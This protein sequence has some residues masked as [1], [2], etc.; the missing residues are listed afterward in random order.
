MSNKNVLPLPGYH[1]HAFGLE[2]CDLCRQSPNPASHPPSARSLKGPTPTGF[3]AIAAGFKKKDLKKMIKEQ[4]GMGQDV[5]HLDDNNDLDENHSDQD[6]SQNAAEVKPVFSG[7]TA[8][9]TLAAAEMENCNQH[10]EERAKSNFSK[11]RV[12]VKAKVSAVGHM[13]TMLDTSKEL[14]LSNEILELAIQQIGSED[15]RS[16]KVAAYDFMDEII[17]R[18]KIAREKGT[19]DEMKYYFEKVEKHMMPLFGDQNWWVRK[20]AIRG[21]VKLSMEDPT[22]VQEAVVQSIP[23]AESYKGIHAYEHVYVCKHID[24]H[25]CVQI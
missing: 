2:R 1:L 8:A 17:V 10:N 19:S 18:T 22:P 14:K 4:P 12:A 24:R 6:D 11:L 21:V 23:T 9:E 20:A 3:E 25:M 7:P 5:A 16:R 15:W 13:G